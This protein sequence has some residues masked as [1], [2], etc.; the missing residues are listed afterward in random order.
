MDQTKIRQYPRMHLQRDSYTSLNGIWDIQI[1]HQDS[2]PE[3]EKFMPI[4][5]PFLPGTK[6]SLCE[7]KPQMNEV[8]WY[9]LQFAYLPNERKTLLHFEAVYQSCTI[10]LNGVELFYHEGGYDAFYVD[11]SQTIKYQN[12]LLVKVVNQK[13]WS[14]PF[15]N[16][17]PF[18]GIYGDVWLEDCGNHMIKD[19]IY[20]W[21]PETQKLAIQLKGN[22]DQSLLTISSQSKVLYQG[23]TN[24]KKYEFIIQEPHLWSPDDPFLYDFHVKTEDDE[25]KSYI[26]LRTV[27]TKIMYKDYHYFYLNQKKYWLNGIIDETWSDYTGPMYLSDEKMYQH[28]LLIKSLGYQAIYKRG[29][30]ERNRWFYFCDLIGLI[31]FQDLSQQSLPFFSWHRKR[32]EDEQEN[33]ITEV[34]KLINGYAY[35][36]SLVALILQNTGLT[37]CKQQ[38]MMNRYSPKYLINMDL[39]SSVNYTKKFD[40]KRLNFIKVGKIGYSTKNNVMQKYQPQRQYMDKIDWYHAMA[41]IFLNEVLT[42]LKKGYAGYFYERFQDSSN[43]NDGLCEKNEEELK[44]DKEFIQKWN[45]RFRRMN[46]DGK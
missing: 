6:A 25:V 4:M 24:D 26:A 37:K 39:Y 31:V 18:M 16:E 40:Y 1:C 3:K 27:K 5:V 45:A 42:K 12:L 9:Q 33:F 14:L 21:Y 44:I 19:I 7:C 22:F 46:N 2:L 17:H 41:N 36:P 29:M 13:T 30:I 28:L 43:Y 10:F 15:Q 23:L 34:N 38:E 35:H 11:V 8:L 32:S 20:Q